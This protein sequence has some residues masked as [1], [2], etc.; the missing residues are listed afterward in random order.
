MTNETSIPPQARLD[1]KVAVVTGGGR[2]VG[3]AAAITLARAGADVI[4]TARTAAEIEETAQQIA[5]DGGRARAIPADVSDWPAVEQLARETAQAF[6]P[7]DIVVANAGVIHPVGDTWEVAPEDWA[8]NLQINLVGMFHT[9]RA[10][11]PGIVE[12]GHGVLILTSSGA[13]AH[14]VP[15][16]SA[17]CAAK[18]GLDH[19]ARNLTA[20]IDQRDLPIRIHVFYPGI[21][22]TAMQ[23]EIRQVSERE[24][25]RV[26]QFRSYHE[27][28][29]LRPPEEPA[30][31]IW[32]LATPMAAEL[33]GQVV[34]IDDAAIR[35]RLAQDLGLAPFQGRGD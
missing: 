32:W 9:V 2:G 29:W 17:Y 26:T 22:A 30:A 21:V 28:G 34:S 5:G 8:Q 24:F 19:F 7:A 33:H 12:R 20:E 27:Q 18:A 15:G 4:V 10:F 13:A 11:L 3:R 35:R 31:L 23:Q 25:S 16:W 14:P 6:G 1:G